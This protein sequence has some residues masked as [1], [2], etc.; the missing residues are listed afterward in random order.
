MLYL[1]FK[2]CKK[3]LHIKGGWVSEGI[4]ILI[5]SSQKCMKS[6]SIIFSIRFSCI[7]YW[8]WDENEKSSHTVTFDQNT[9]I[10]LSI[11]HRG[12]KRGTNELKIWIYLTR[13]GNLQRLKVL[14]TVFWI[15]YRLK[16]LILFC[17]F[18]MPDNHCPLGM[19]V[20]LGN[21][22]GIWIKNPTVPLRSNH[23]Y[24]GPKG[25]MLLGFLGKSCWCAWLPAF[26][27]NSTSL[28]SY[29]EKVS[30]ESLSY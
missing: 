2:T 11:H 21:M 8:R 12:F 3:A 15:E 4:F 19:E 1:E 13:L 24:Q 10:P 16:F 9:F 6:L 18:E 20:D 27:T 28:W 5:P 23:L 26:R 14:F 29:S 22:K 30:P 7:F 25:K 17:F